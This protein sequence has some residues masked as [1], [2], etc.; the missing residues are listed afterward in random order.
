MEGRKRTYKE[1]GVAKES[2]SYGRLVLV[3][4]S[5]ETGEVFLL[6]EKTIPPGETIKHLIPQDFLAEMKENRLL[7]LLRLAGEKEEQIGH[8]VY[9]PLKKSIYLGAMET[10]PGHRRREVASSLIAYIKTR[11]RDIWLIPNSRAE[12]FYR[13]LG[14]FSSARY[15]GWELPA[16]K[17]LAKRRGETTRFRKFIIRPRVVKR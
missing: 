3:Q 6:R 10:V 13:K 5:P 11:G 15:N 14:F 9:A 16:E 7:S 4:K 1:L 2:A 17:Q 8:A 12:P